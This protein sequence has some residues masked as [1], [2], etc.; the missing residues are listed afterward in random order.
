MKKSLSIIALIGVI[1]LCKITAF[2]GDI[3][4]SLL[5]DDGALLFFGEVISY[6][7]TD[8]IIIVLP[9]QKIKGDINIDAEQAYENGI[10]VGKD[11][12]IPDDGKIYLMAYC[13]GNNPLYVFH[14]T[15]TDTETLAIEGIEGLGMWERMQ[16]Y[17]NDGLYEQKEIERL[18]RVTNV[19]TA[20][21]IT[22]A[23]SELTLAPAPANI[24]ETKSIN[25]WLYGSIIVVIGIIISG[26][27]IYLRKF[28]DATGS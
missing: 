10:F 6:D 14:I 16:E 28:R 8:N 13:D 9:T 7:S 21:S 1:F 15:N 3:A 22:T 11:D 24:E 2:A 26:I 5:N 18:S 20:P 4:E 23:E 17:L 25:N 12:F 19:A 27:V